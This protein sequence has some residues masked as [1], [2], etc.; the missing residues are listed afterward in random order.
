LRLTGQRHFGADRHHRHVVDPQ[1]AR[2]QQSERWPVDVLALEH[3]DHASE[4]GPVKRAPPAQRIVFS[5]ESEFRVHV[6]WANGN[7]QSAQIGRNPITSGWYAFECLP[8]A[9]LGLAGAEQKTG[10]CAVAGHVTYAKFA[11][12]FVLPP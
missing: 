12:A 10:R 8:D 11:L 9:D 6:P 7:V 3:V 5:I 1:V 2:R 4:L